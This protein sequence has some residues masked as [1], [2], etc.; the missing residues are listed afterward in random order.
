M[1]KLW[2]AGPLALLL[3]GGLLAGQAVKSPV[4]LPL[5]FEPLPDSR[6]FLAHGKPSIVISSQ[7]VH[8]GAVRMRF[9]GAQ[10]HAAPAGIDPLPSRSNYFIG[11]DPSRWRSNVTNYE[12]VR[13]TGIYPNVDLA[14]HGN[15]GRLE[16]DF[17]LA[18]GADPRLLRQVFDGAT[19]I[20]VDRNGDL[21]VR[22]GNQLLRFKKPIASQDGQPVEVRY[23][24]RS[25]REAGFRLGRYD[26]KKALVIDPT[27]VFSTFLGGSNY[28]QAGP[29]NPLLEA[30]DSALGIAVDAAGNSYVTGY[31]EAHA[32]TVLNAEQST[33]AFAA[34]PG[35]MCAFIAKFSPQGTLLYSTYL[36]GTGSDSGNAI[37]VDSTGAVY[38]TGVTTAPDFPLKNPF[39]STRTAPATAFVSKLS[40]DGST[41][42][43]STYLG[44]S[45]SNSL[46]IGN[47]GNGIAVDSSGN[48][49]VSGTTASTT[50]PLLN[51]AQATLAGTQAAFVTK[52]N[53]TGSALVFSTYLGGTAQEAGNGIALDASG[54][55]YVAGWTQ[56]AN[57]PTVTPAQPTLH[58]MQNAFVTKFSSTGTILYSTFLG[59]HGTD[60]ANAIAVD[61]SGSAYVTGSTTSTSFP[62]V[63]AMQSTIAGSNDGFVTKLA[64]AGSSLVYST[65]FGGA[66]GF[67]IAV[68]AAGEAYVAGA[69]ASNSFPVVNAVQSTGGTPA[70]AGFVSPGNNAVI[71]KLSADG[72]KFIYST[73]LGGTLPTGGFALGDIARGIG[74]DSTG[75]AYVAGQAGTGDFPTFNAF[76]PKIL[77]YGNAFVAMIS[78][79]ASIPCVYQVNPP[80]PT[81]TLS[82]FGG[83]GRFSVDAN[84]TSC[85][86]QAVSSAPWLTITQGA[87]GSGVGEV[88]FS[89]GFNP[90]FAAQTATI[91]VLGQSFSITQPPVSYYAGIA[92]A[93][94][95]PGS[96]ARMPLTLNSLVTFNSLSLELVIQPNGSAPVLTAPIGFQV[97][98]GV[99]APQIAT[100]ASGQYQI[101]NLTWNSISPALPTGTTK[102]GEFLVTLP[103]SAVVGQT[104]ATN[105]VGQGTGSQPTVQ[106]LP[107]VTPT[108]SVANPAP[109]PE[110]LLP[111]SAAPGGPARTI[112]VNGEGFTTT[113]TVLWNNSARDTTFVS[114]TQ[115]QAAIT[116]ADIAAAGTAQITVSNPAPGGGVS[117]ALSFLI[118][119]TPLPVVGTNG[120][121]DAA[122][123]GL[124]VAGNTIVS[125]FGVNMAASTALAASVP[126]PTSLGGVSVLVDGVAAPL[127]FVAPGQINLQLPWRLLASRVAGPTQTSIVVVNNGLNSSATTVQLSPNAPAIFTINEQGS[128]QGAI[129]DASTGVFMAPANSIPFITSKP[130]VV[131][132]NI[133][134]YC[135]GLGAIQ[136]ASFGDGAPSSGI[137]N[138]VTPAQVTIGGVNATVSYTGL[139][140]GFVGLYQVNVQIPAGA[141]SGNA[142][143]VVLSINGAMSNMV[144]IA[145]Q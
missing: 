58:G 135:T 31:T 81:P 51:P 138:T 133:A 65:Y 88:V 69:T 113:S 79:T 28:T 53:P 82:S 71:S 40:T 83:A 26:A 90:T 50:F 15:D 129:L 29:Q 42:V 80:L 27:L 18:P 33:C 143:P 84:S 24:L 9:V 136:G 126:L 86:W 52:L 131:G 47:V 142:I 14:Y 54:N 41:L 105:S 112:T 104:Y 94:G 118:T 93:A 55:A 111:S 10:D 85:S 120:V 35:V 48:A 62:T 73:Y 7:G 141:G 103:A 76:Q 114:E 95:L 23:V 78:E 102:L 19:R 99:P 32:F 49:Y 37:A 22:A 109:T 130:A 75:Q 38:V 45:G 139:A 11:S 67:A 16:Y 119:S 44:G 59:G 124:T 140:P 39:Q 144:T 46:V 56:S 64:P 5:R 145:I 132:E 57:F 128:G 96:V 137:V 70:Q 107:S 74:L 91:T 116:P 43:Y 66:G 77:G 61:S 1:C 97:A 12:K 2:I 108:V 100:S 122:R 106:V 89:A 3:A 6:D 72:S 92:S 34:S 25:R 87:N 115:L 8:L 30:G 21:L 13:Y 125:I 134:I 123:Y 121:V 127:F 98:P 110:W 4:Q 117:A 101:I 63:N 36:G 68:D 60:S 17:V 20:T